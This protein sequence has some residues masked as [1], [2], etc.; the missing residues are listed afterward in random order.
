MVE[1]NL[2]PTRR[3]DTSKWRKNCQ[4]MRDY[5]QFYFEGQGLSLA[6]EASMRFDPLQLNS[7]QAQ[8][9]GCDPDYSVWLMQP[10]HVDT[11]NPEL[12]E[13]RTAGGHVHVSF[14]IDEN[15]T[16]PGV[17][18]VTR[19]VK[20]LDLYLGVPSVLFDKDTTRRAFYGKAGAFRPKSY[21]VE[22]RVLSGFWFSDPLYSDWVY[23][24][25]HDAFRWLRNRRPERLDETLE[26]HSQD[27]Q[28]A[29]NNADKALAER[30]VDNFGLRKLGHNAD[31]AIDDEVAQLRAN[32]RNA[33]RPDQQVFMALGDGYEAQAQAVGRGLR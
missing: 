21:G 5:L 10:N 24:S 22:Y 30:L 20:T 27:I 16:P 4:K 25:V 14:D 9:F 33:I 2:P 18:D 31:I 26:Q 19:V 3:G 15:G 32:L 11:S 17:E 1:F 8:T 29:I 13:L 6:Y 23:E 28:A 7:E 12:R